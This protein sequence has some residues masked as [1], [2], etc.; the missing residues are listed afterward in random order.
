MKKNFTL[1]ILIFLT[2]FVSVNAQKTAAKVEIE[3]EVWKEFVAEDKSYKILFPEQTEKDK[4]T[5]EQ[6]RK[7]IKADEKDKFVI[8]GDINYGVVFKDFPAAPVDEMERQARYKI[9]L[10]RQGNETKEVFAQKHPG[11]EFSAEIDQG[12]VKYD[13]FSR[14]FLVQQRLFDVSIGVPSLKKLSPARRKVYQAKIDK[15]FNSFTPLEIP[16]AKYEPVPLLPKDFKVSLSGQKFQSDLL[17][18]S[19]QLPSDWITEIHNPNRKPDP[20][21]EKE[22]VMLR[23]IWRNREGLVQS[24][25]PTK[26]AGLGIILNRREFADMTLQNFAESMAGFL[27]NSLLSKE[28]TPLPVKLVTINGSNFLMF[29][30]VEDG[31]QKGYYFADSGKWILEIRTQYK[32]ESDKKLIENA[33]NTLELSK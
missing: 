9:Q 18:L 30:Q 8:V 14:L 3:P 12:G 33:L 24:G 16:P 6:L 7:L 25:S 13:N 2:F 1:P 29:E 23:L 32:Q 20:E 26:E 27:G 21:L 5:T 4:E 31:M 22:S 28:K 15:F 11:V 17:K 19:I 10:T